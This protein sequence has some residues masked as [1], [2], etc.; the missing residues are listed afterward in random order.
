MKPYKDANESR[1]DTMSIESVKQFFTQRNVN[2]A[3]MELGKSGATVELAAKTIG[4]TP[5]LVAKTLAF[6]LKDKNILIV[7]RGDARIAN[8]KYRE[9]FNTKA[10]ML[11]ADEVLEVTGHPVGGVCPF[12]LKNELEIFMDLS[13]KDFQYVYPAAGGIDAAMKISPA[14]M[15]ELTLAQWIDVCE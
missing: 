1:I 7:T 4:I 8:K 9:F 12:G 5:E 2:F 11:N 10:K 15:A 13:I 3:L 14:L 6:K